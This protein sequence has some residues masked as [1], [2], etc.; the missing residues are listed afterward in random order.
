M[1]R[2]MEKNRSSGAGSV[3]TETWS[4]LANG[5]TLLEAGYSDLGTGDSGRGWGLLG[6]SR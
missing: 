6:C 3:E 5:V 1:L 2:R 4:E